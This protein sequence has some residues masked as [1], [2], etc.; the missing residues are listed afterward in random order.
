MPR[1]RRRRIG[2]FVCAHGLVMRGCVGDKCG[3]ALK[4]PNLPL[5]HEYLALQ[6][7]ARVLRLL[8]RHWWD[9]HYWPDIFTGQPGNPGS[10]WIARFRRLM[11]NTLQQAGFNK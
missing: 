4:C 6:N 3:W 8:K 1:K 7:C 2:D 9:K 10:M 11:N 5:Y